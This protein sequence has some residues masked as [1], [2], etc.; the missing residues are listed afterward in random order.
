[1]PEW[2]WSR[3]LQFSR[4]LMIWLNATTGVHYITLYLFLSFSLLNSLV[5]KFVWN[6]QLD[7]DTWLLVAL[8]PETALSSPVCLQLL[9]KVPF[10]LWRW[11]RTMGQIPCSVVS[12]A[13]GHC[14][15]SQLFLELTVKNLFDRCL[16]S[17]PESCERA[18]WDPHHWHDGAEGVFCLCIF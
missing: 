6:P 11:L 5:F 2:Q 8:F 15:H 18:F 12:F 16:I 3:K 10:T 13:L 4:L 9:G 7:N 14:P 1:M 17:L